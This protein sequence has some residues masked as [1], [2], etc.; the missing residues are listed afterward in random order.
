MSESVTFTGTSMFGGKVVGV[1]GKRGT[2]LLHFEVEGD[3]FGESEPVVLSL[4]RDSLPDLLLFIQ[5]A[6]ARPVVK[7]EGEGE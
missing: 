4:S 2:V 3:D 1:Y 7:A 5:S 6:M